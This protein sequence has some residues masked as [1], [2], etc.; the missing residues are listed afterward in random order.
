MAQSTISYLWR[1][2]KASE[3]F[4]SGV[5]LH[6]HTNQSHETLDFLANFGNQYPWMRPLLTRLEQ[7]SERMHGVRVDYAAS[8]WTPPMTPRLAFDLETKQIEKLNLTPMV[9]IT[10][11]DNIKAPMLL[12]D[13][14]QRAADSGFRGV[15]RSIRHAVLSPGHT[16]PSQRQGNRVDGDTGRLYRASQ[17]RAL[18]R[19]FARSP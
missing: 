15:D 16:Q 11:H 3:G 4:Q 1:D 10:D 19:D 12:Q 14:S 6:S 8:Y 17:R 5:S 13:R 2:R 9:S 7:R 18:D